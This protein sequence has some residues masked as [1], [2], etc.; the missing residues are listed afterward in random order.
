MKTLRLARLVF[1]VVSLFI[2]LAMLMRPWPVAAQ[3]GSPVASLEPATTI[4]FAADTDSNSPSV[5]SLVSGRQYLYVLNSV[6]GRS[7]QSRGLSVDKLA[8]LNPI[9][10]SPAAPFGG[11][12]FEAIVPDSA[13]SYWYGY[14]HNERENVVCPGSGKVIPRIGAARS[15]DRGL[16]WRDL[17]TVVEAPPGSERCDTTN[18][19]FVGGVGDFSVVLDEDQ[20]YLYFYYTQYFEKNAEVGVAVARITWANRNS[21]TNKATVWNAGAWLPGSTQRVLQSDGKTANQFV[22][23]AATPV[24]KAVDSWDGGTPA[25]DVFWGPSIHWNTALG[26]YVMLLNRANSAMWTQEGIYVSYSRTLDDPRAWS[27]PTK[28]LGGGSWYPQVVGLESD[29]TD[30]RAGALARFFMGGRSQYLIR[31]SRE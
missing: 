24:P 8:P 17:G 20:Q 5:W 1:G 2:G 15:S 25:V 30:K 29:G 3:L 26:M 18:H 23:R 6:A 11:S 28:L 13:S 21:P 10:W 14:Y 27:P 31:F 9:K 22:Y 19:Y 16:T 4:A 12:W 7:T